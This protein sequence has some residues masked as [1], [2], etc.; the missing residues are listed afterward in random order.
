MHDIYNI[1]LTETEANML[2]AITGIG[3]MIHQITAW[4]ACGWDSIKM[5]ETVLLIRSRQRILYFPR[6]LN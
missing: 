5:P 3:R 6:D 4:L 2:L 1:M